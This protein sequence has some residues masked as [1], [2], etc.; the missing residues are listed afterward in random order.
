MAHIARAALEGIAYQCADVLQAMEA[1]SGV[2]LSQ[3][4]VDGGAVANNLLMQFQSDILGIPVV[5]PKNAETTAMGAAYLAGLATGFYKSTDEISTQWAIDRTFEPK[6][7]ADQRNKL[8]SDWN[9]AVSRAKA[10]AS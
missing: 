4:R 2:K 10:W 9:K 6:M 3:L 5:R 7:G 1:D 8:R